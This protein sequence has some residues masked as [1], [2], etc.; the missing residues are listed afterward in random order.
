[1]GASQI[2]ARSL[3][4]IGR[5]V[6][7]E[8]IIRGWSHGGYTLGFVTADHRHGWYDKKTGEWGWHDPN[9]PHPLHYTSCHESWPGF[10]R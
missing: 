9:D 3:R 1:M 2:N 8:D 5:A 6:G 10:V 7:V 4:R